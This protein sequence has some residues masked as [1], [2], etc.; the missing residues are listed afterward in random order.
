MSDEEIFYVN[1]FD[2]NLEM[3]GSEMIKASREMY[4]NVPT[5]VSAYTEAGGAVKSAEL[6][7]ASGFTAIFHRG[8]P[9]VK[10][11]KVAS[12]KIYTLNED[13][14]DFVSLNFPLLRRFR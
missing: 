9:F 13:S 10:D 3:S 4:D 6:G 12:G 1:R 5:Y 14:I 2:D 11:E 7:G 8:I